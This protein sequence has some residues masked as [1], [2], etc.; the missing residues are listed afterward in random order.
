[1]RLAFILELKGCL[2]VS[3]SNHHRSIR[4]IDLMVVE[5][6][7]IIIAIATIIATSSHLRVDL[8]F[9]KIVIFTYL[10]FF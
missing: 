5:I 8:I 6:M 9:N 4:D 3:G 2:S 7:I 10:R 1:M